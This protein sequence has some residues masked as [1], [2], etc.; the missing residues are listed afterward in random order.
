[1]SALSKYVCRKG[2]VYYAIERLERERALEARRAAQALADAE[3]LHLDDVEPGFVHSPNI[4]FNG[5]AVAKIRAAVCRHFGARMI[6]LISRRRTKSVMLPRQIG[7]HMCRLY[8]V[9]SYPQIGIAFGNRDHTTAL[10]ADRKISAMRQSSEYVEKHIRA[11]E[12]ALGVFG[13]AEH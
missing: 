12:R 10:H 5:I 8:T 2:P 6:D 9:A 11:I 4:E 1:V 3:L 7:M 13:E